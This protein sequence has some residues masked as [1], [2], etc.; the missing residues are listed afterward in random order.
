M[1]TWLCFPSRSWGKRLI[2]HLWLSLGLKVFAWTHNIKTS[3]VCRFQWISPWLRQVFRGCDWCQ[4]LWFST[5][6]LILCEHWLVLLRFALLIIGDVSQRLSFRRS[7]IFHFF[8][9]AERPYVLLM[10]WGSKLSW[11]RRRLSLHFRW[12]LFYN[13]HP[14][15]GV[16]GAL[17]HSLGLHSSCDVLCGLLL[18]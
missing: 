5:V 13:D 17:S 2:F 6:I 15:Y 18:F 4:D 11:S 14:T 9:A 8:V 12:R 16:S 7:L 10:P 3:L 1:L